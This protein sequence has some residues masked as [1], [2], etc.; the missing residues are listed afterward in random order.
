MIYNTTFY[1]TDIS[2]DYEYDPGKQFHAYVPGYP[3]PPLSVEIH[4]IFVGETSI[5]EIF[6]KKL[7]VELKE[8]LIE[9]HLKWKYYLV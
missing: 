4:D 8:K 7:L 6:D 9:M 3:G 1:Y 5:F 2:V